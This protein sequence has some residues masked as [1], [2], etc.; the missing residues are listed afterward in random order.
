MGVEIRI[1]PHSALQ[2]SGSYRYFRNQD[3]EPDKGPK[4]Y[5]DYRYYPWSTSTNDGL[6]LSPFVGIGSLRVGRGDDFNLPDTNR[7]RE[8][9]AGVLLGYQALWSRFTLEGF[10]GP[11]YRRVASVGSYLGVQRFVWLRAGFTAGL[12]FGQR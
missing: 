4:F 9:E 5:L 7:K 8:Q 2:V 6:F 1:S 12:R 11:A 3:A 10:A